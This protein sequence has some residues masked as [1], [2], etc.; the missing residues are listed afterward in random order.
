MV[1]NTFILSLS[2]SLILRTDKKN[3]LGCIDIHVHMVMLIHSPG[4][5]LLYF[6]G[7]EII[8][9]LY[10]SL[11]R[12]P[13][14]RFNALCLLFNHF[15]LFYFLYYEAIVPALNYISVLAF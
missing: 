4:K 12:S 3:A 11:E 1:C 9:V 2:I 7:S 8:S 15:Y 13:L 5:S 10:N 14:T 6:F